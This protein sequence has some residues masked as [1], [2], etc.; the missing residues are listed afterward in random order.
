MAKIIPRVRLKR[1]VIPRE[2][3]RGEHGGD[4]LRWRRGD[5]IPSK[6]CRAVC[7]HHRHIKDCDTGAWIPALGDIQ[8]YYLVGGIAW[9]RTLFDGTYNHTTREEIMA[10][11]HC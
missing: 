1:W 8:T 6:L 2:L 10:P 9:L 3:H 7:G 11:R 4:N 5:N